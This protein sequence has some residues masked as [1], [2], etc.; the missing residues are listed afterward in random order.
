MT[1]T[2]TMHALETHHMSNQPPARR[3][4]IAPSQA[5]RSL[6][7]D[8]KLRNGT[9]SS[10]SGVQDDVQNTTKRRPPTQVSAYNNVPSI[11]AS[12]R[13]VSASHGGTQAMAASSITNSGQR[14]PPPNQSPSLGSIP[15]KAPSGRAVADHLVDTVSPISSLE[16]PNPRDLRPKGSVSVSTKTHEASA[17]YRPSGNDGSSAVPQKAAGTPGNRRVTTETVNN[18]FRQSPNY[19]QGSSIPSQAKQASMQQDPYVARRTGASVQPRAHSRGVPTDPQAKQSPPPPEALVSNNQPISTGSGS[20]APASVYVQGAPTSRTDQ[21]SA[22]SDTLVGG[23]RAIAMRSGPYAQPSDPVRD[24]PH[25][26]AE[27]SSELLVLNKQSMAKRSN[28]IAQ[29]SDLLN[30]ESKDV[31]YTKDDASKRVTCNV[32]KLFS[33]LVTARCSQNT[34]NNTFG[35]VGVDDLGTEDVIIA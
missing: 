24:V 9:S 29:S 35:V 5:T 32:F 28:A 31:S 25:S 4:D 3:A 19:V 2:G 18:G 8:L 11:N 34:Q 6:V 33:N 20:N 13:H 17:R 27:R 12:G 21:S 1:D 10:R 15:S 30:D 22:L 14:D 23:K 26:Q 16:T 7:D